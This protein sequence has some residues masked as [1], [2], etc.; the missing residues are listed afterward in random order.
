MM[1]VT[2]VAGRPTAVRTITMVTS[3]A[4]GTP[5]APM[6]AT[7]AVIL[8]NEHV[9]KVLFGVLS[10]PK[11]LSSIISHLPNGNNLASI[12]IVVVQLSYEYRSNSFI[13]CS[14]IHIDSRTNWK[15]KAS[16]PLVN[17][18]VLFCTSERDRQSG[19]ADVVKIFVIIKS[20]ILGRI[21]VFIDY[22]GFKKV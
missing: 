17:P 18:V 4:F 16:D 14:A 9:T 15:D 21:A 22:C 12:Q 19:W 6:L 5:A 1:R 13:Q 7:V 8:W 10:F 3:P 2:S 11:P 20:I